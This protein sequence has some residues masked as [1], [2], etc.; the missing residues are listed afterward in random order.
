ML[1]N[2]SA[3]A[4]VPK[5]KAIAARRL[6][7]DDYAELERKRSVLEVT[8]A[9]Q[10]HPYF[11]DSLKGL[12]PMN[13]HRAQIEE[14]LRKDIFYKYE[15][16]M[17]YTYKKG[18]FGT[19]FLMRCEI[20]ELLAKIRLLS[21][22]FRHH[23][24]VQL[25]GF[26]ASKTSFSLLKLAKAET[27]EECV[28]VVAGTPYAKVL[29]SVMPPRGKLPDYLLCEHAFWDY[30]YTTVIRQ[31]DR[32]IPGH[33]RQDTKRLFLQQAEI[34]N[35]DLLYRAKAFYN[36]Q[37]PP[38]RIRALLLNV[39]YILPPRKLYEMAN[40][41]DLNEFL[42]LYND[43]RAKAV[44]GERTA[45]LEKPSDIEADRALYHTAER[46]LHF[47]CTPQTVLAATLCL[48]D[49]QRSNIINIIEG[50][51]YGLPVAQINAFL[52]Y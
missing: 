2:Q 48:A 28:P 23:Y 26:L 1:E 34:Y 37:L 47:S 40:A 22:G 15:S 4:I 29:A 32:S 8:T 20:T 31:I 19:Y 43:S 51:R 50:V 41:R 17:H 46:L 12:S 21:M 6:M 16:L 44:Y 25:P 14:A 45:D 36:T 18:S 10:N 52:K 38:Q 42:W 39:S 13:L 24:I 9:L 5:A 7:R 3:L 30:Y 35:L 27:I 11:A 49:I 33:T